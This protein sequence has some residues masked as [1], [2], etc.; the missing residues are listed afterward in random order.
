MRQY[1]GVEADGHRHLV[2]A[3]LCV[4]D[5]LPE[6]RTRWIEVMDGGSCFWDAT[7]DLET[8]EIIQLGSHG[9]AWDRS[10]QPP[11]ATLSAGGRGR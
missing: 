10:A 6:W 9:A 3:G 4:P 11:A 2:V 1:T 8:G 5:E 7:M